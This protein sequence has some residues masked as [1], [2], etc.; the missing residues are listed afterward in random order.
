[1]EW[2]TPAQPTLYDQ[3]E[4][5]TSTIRQERSTSIPMEEGELDSETDQ[6]NSVLE[7]P[8]INWARY[9]GAKS[10]QYVQMGHTYKIIEEE[11]KNWDL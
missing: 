2:P 11:D 1:M 8:A 10:V 7:V 4:P 3:P 6:G 5:S 9:N